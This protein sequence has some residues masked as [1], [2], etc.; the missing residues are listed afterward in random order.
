MNV[1]AADQR[2]LSLRYR[3]RRWL[4]AASAIVLLGLALTG[5]MQLEPVSS[6][7]LPSWRFWAWEFWSGELW[8]WDLWKVA[9]LHAL[10]FYLVHALWLRRRFAIDPALLPLVHLLTGVGLMLMLSMNEG[11]YAPGFVV[12]SASGALVIGAVSFLDTRRA[13][14]RRRHPVWLALAL[15]IAF[16]LFVAGSGPAGSGARV[17]LDL[18]YAGRVQPVEA[19]KLCL[20]LFMAGFFAHNWTFLRELRGRWG[21]RQLS[22]LTRS[23][24]RLPRVALPRL[25]DVV[26]VALGVAAALGSCFVLRDMGPAL[27]IGCTFLLLYGTARGRWSAVFC[28]FAAML[29]GFYLIYTTGSVPVVA[30]RMSMLLSP[31]DNLVTGGEHLAHAYWALASGGLTGVGLGL[32][33]AA[34]IPAAHTDMVLPALG[35]ELGFA[36]LLGLLVLYGVLLVRALHTARRASGAFGLFLGIGAA[37]MILFQLFLIAGGTTGLAP[38]SGVVTPFVSFG[39]SSMLVNCALVGLLASISRTARPPDRPLRSDDPFASPLLVA[40]ALVVLLLSAVMLRT[41]FVQAVR[42]DDWIIKPALVPRQAGDRAFVYNPRVYDARRRLG[43]GTIYDR[44]GVVV[45]VD[46]TA[47]AEPARRYPFGAETFY[48]LG[49]VNRRV[50]W[51]ADNSLYAEHRFLSYLRGYDNH[52]ATIRVDGR[53]VVR[54]DYREL[55]PLIGPPNRAATALM[56][57]PRDLQLTTDVRL[58][59]RVTKALAELVPEGRTGAA[60]VL[61]AFTGEVLASATIPL[62]GL[63][64]A[65]HAD[66][67]V[68]DRGFGVGA[69]PPGST[70]KLVTAMAALQ[71]EGARA[72]RWSHLVRAS[73]RYARRGEPTGTVDMHRALVSSSNVYFAALAREVVG[74]ERLAAMARAF[75]FRIGSSGLSVREQVDLLKEPDNL[76]QAGFGQGPVLASPLEI[77]RLAAAVANGGISLPARWIRTSPTDGLPLSRSSGTRVIAAEHARFLAGAMRDVVLEGTAEVIRVSTVAISGKTGTAEEDRPGA[78]PLNHAWFAGFAP[79]GGSDGASMRIAALDGSGSGAI[80]PRRIIA[81]GVLVEEGGHG[82]TVAAPIARAIVEAAAELGIIDHA[83]S[84]S[85]IRHRSTPGPSTLISSPGR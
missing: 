45:A 40:A 34:A 49:D 64:A 35:E 22:G 55:R 25:R 11:G 50:K 31:W 78:P 37:L 42:A 19:L 66:P 36:G 32:G 72:Q 53:D 14:W 28:G 69:K 3:E 33:S 13:F 54:Y 81:V 7:Q 58:Q 59:R 70:F 6:G 80:R 29:A 83:G 85:S 1:D 82:G 60:V 52:P 18:P 38:L 43:R 57:R 68:F 71:A 8:S 76:R 9:A 65:A 44:N 63:D 26:P 16:V 17:N 61:D 74:P 62:P 24:V 4:A 73:D 47:G 39:K 30:E 77:A 20:L 21:V 51:G 46:D 67:L 10:P 2:A 56:A 41:G 12:G 15:V 79:S 84:A 23:G 27:I 48:L 5:A 75:G